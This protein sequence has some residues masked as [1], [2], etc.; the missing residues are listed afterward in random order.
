MGAQIKEKRV[1]TESEERGR[2]ILAWACNKI[3]E[4]SEKTS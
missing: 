4:M 3:R 1:Q 2:E